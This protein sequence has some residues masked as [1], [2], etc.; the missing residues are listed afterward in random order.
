L[1]NAF[2]FAKPS[3][4][5]LE[6]VQMNHILPSALA[7]LAA[8]SVWQPLP[9]RSA[10]SDQNWSALGSGMNSNVYALV[11][12]GSDLYAGGNFTNAGGVSA[13]FVARWS[14]T[15]WSALGAGVGGAPPGYFPVVYA[16]AVSGT[17]MYA[18]GL[19]TSAGGTPASRIAKWNGSS[20]SAL[21]AG[22]AGAGFGGGYVGALAVMGSDLFVAGSFLSAGAVAANNIAKWNGTNWSALGPGTGGTYPYYGIVYAL[23]VSGSDLYVG[24][25]FVQA[26]G[27]AANSVAKWDGTNWSAVG[28]GMNGSVSALAVFGTDLYAGGVFTMAGGNPANHIARWNSGNWSALASGMDNIVEALAVSGIELYAGGWLTN[29][30]GIAANYIAKW[31]ESSWAALGSGLNNTVHALA[32]S[33]TDLYVGGDFTTAGV[34]SANYIARARIGCTATSLVATN[35]SAFIRFSGVTG[36]QYNVERATGLSLNPPTD[37][38]TLTTDP[39][40]AASDGSFTFSD[41]NAPPGMAYYRAVQR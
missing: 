35:S 13:N 40:S 4:S 23:V 28:T 38:T 20:W 15:N 11:A 2:R 5:I 16:L 39:V 10:F 29:A 21:G 17:N 18:G 14:G 24:G 31:N 37:W 30:G 6:T 19:F 1:T 8:A 34:T 33:G 12:S 32:I 22:I 26:G 27:N 36:Y 3:L 25:N 9:A 7:I 41:T